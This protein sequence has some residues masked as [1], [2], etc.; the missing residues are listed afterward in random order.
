MRIL[1]G[2][3]IL[4]FVGCK[5]N[6][7]AQPQQKTKYVVVVLI[8]GARYSETFGDNLFQYIPRLHALQKHGTTLT[9]FYNDSVTFTVNGHAA[10]TTG[11]YET[12]ANN[13]FELPKHP[14]FLQ[15]YL[16]KN[17]L[18]ANKAW[19]VSSKDKLAVLAN[20]KDSVYANIDTPMTNCGNAGLHTGYRND[21]ETYNTAIQILKNYKP[22]VVFIS[23]KEPDNMGHAGNWP[24]YLAGLKQSDAYTDSI[25][26]FLNSDL[27]YKNQTA[28]F[29]TNDHGRHLDGIADG[30]VS[31]GDNCAGC[32]HIMLYASGPDF[33]SN[34][35]ISKKYNQTDIHATICKLLNLQAN[36]GNVITE[37]FK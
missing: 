20:C 33:K 30:F 12:L 7:E 34:H 25:F 28:F 37:L 10:V 26:K 17:K 21:A 19:I 15:Q 13:G 35:I 31:H 3:C 2:L 23:F 27:F 36:G 5:S 6:P 18:E 9:S 14:G 32:K 4:I 1:I 29:V 16:Y 22:H 24:G 8:D 11:V